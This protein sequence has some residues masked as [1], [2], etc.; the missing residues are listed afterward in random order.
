MH[1]TTSL[2]SILMWRY[3]KLTSRIMTE[4]GELIKTIQLVQINWN[5]LSVKTQSNMLV[6]WVLWY[7]DV[8]HTIPNRRKPT[9]IYLFKFLK[10][11]FNF[12]DPRV[13]RRLPN[14]LP[15]ICK[16]PIIGGAKIIDKLRVL[17]LKMSRISDAPEDGGYV[18]CKMRNLHAH[19]VAVAAD[20]HFQNL[21]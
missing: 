1:K 20:P 4:K 11:R 8:K 18:K 10:P 15:S 14:F 13:K 2:A 19:V 3:C 6:V 9:V 5:E 7:K 16:N 17:W 21:V 12:A